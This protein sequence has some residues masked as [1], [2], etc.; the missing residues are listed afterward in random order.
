MVRW[1]VAIGMVALVATVHAQKDSIRTTPSPWFELTAGLHSPSG[2][3]GIGVGVPCGRHFT[4]A[5]AAGF[6]GGAEGKHLSAGAEF[7]ITTLDST[8]IAAF[9]YWTYTIGRVVDDHPRYGSWTSEGQML[10]LG[11]AFRVQM[12]RAQLV[13]RAGYAWFIQVP[14]V[15]MANG[16]EASMDL[17][18]G[19][20]EGLLVS[21]SA[22]FPLGATSEGY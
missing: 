3:F 16:K 20:P 6:G 2:L 4:P 15:H 18:E 1:A 17:R 13:V 11:A 8:N 19:N 10:K 22:R 21:V 14:V 7:P 5:V 9:A 12:G